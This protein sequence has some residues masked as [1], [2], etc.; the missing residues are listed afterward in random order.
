MSETKHRGPRM[1]TNLVKQADASGD[2][3]RVL[4]NELVTERELPFMLERDWPTSVLKPLELFDGMGPL[5]SS[6]T[7]DD[8]TVIFAPVHRG[9]AVKVSV[10]D[11]AVHLRIGATC[12][13]QLESLITMLTADYPHA[14]S[15]PNW[16]NVNFWSYGPQGPKRTNRRLAV[17]GWPEIADNYHQATREELERLMAEGFRPDGGGQLYLWRGTP[18]TGKTWAIRALM[19][20]WHQWAKFHYITDPEMFFGAHADYMLSVLLEE[21]RHDSS[22]PM[23]HTVLILEDS[24]ELMTI[25]AKQQTGQ[26]LSRL[27]NTVDGLVGQGL[28]L[29]VLVT[30][31]EELGKLHP[32][33]C[34]PG[35]CAMNLPFQSLSTL[36]AREW[37]KRRGGDVTPLASRPHRLCDLFAMSKGITV[38]EPAL[39]GFTQSDDDH[40]EF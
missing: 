35:R 19:S 16:V 12:G 23:K 10:Y 28:R 33:V 38:A 2:M 20:S 36:E 5:V 18:G 29:L 9:Y 22:E 1:G 8:G 26:A 6:A 24:G 7:A 3:M 11:G 31:N 17:T 40:L 39:T 4:F 37:M 13:D 27:L 14:E 21:D 34:R 32:A 30:T 25:D 15:K